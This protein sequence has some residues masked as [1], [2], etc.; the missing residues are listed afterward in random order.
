MYSLAKAYARLSAGSGRLN[1]V[2]VADVLATPVNQVSV[3]WRGLVMMLRHH[4]S[5]DVDEAFFFT[6]KAAM[7]HRDFNQE[8]TVAQWLTFIGDTRLETVENAVK[9]TDF[10]YFANA[11]MAGYKVDLT[12]SGARPSTELPK[13][14]QRDLFI[15]HKTVPAPLLYTNAIASVN[16]FLHR[17]YVSEWGYYVQEGG[18]TIQVANDNRV[19]LLSFANLGGCQ[20]IPIVESM[21]Q[22][23]PEEG[24]LDTP[25]YIN[26]PDFD[27]TGKTAFLSIGGRLLP[28][29][30][31][32]RSVG[33]RSFEFR[34]LQY[35]ILQH[36]LE[37]EKVIDCSAIRALLTKKDGNPTA[38]SVD[39]SFSKEFLKAYLTMP[40]TFLIAVNS[41]GVFVEYDD[42]EP[43]QSPG[44]FLAGYGLFGPLIADTGRLM[45][46][47]LIKEL[48]RWVVL[49][50]YG[51]RDNLLFEKAPWMG[52]NVVDSRCIGSKPK[53]KINPRHMTIG[54]DRFVTKTA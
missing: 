36:F 8:R 37:A 42:I 9:K 43:T 35:P 19:S 12:R 14:A 11:F 26:T 6:E 4:I 29:G 20:T 30:N 23:L 49:T 38:V 53:R 2:S 40:Q 21:I 47:S 46:Y 52:Q 41:P 7:Y 50:S 39:E 31:V 25:L 3:T 13:A 5:P 34:A 28:L 33:E 16:G 45:D 18:K 44:A 1:E 22:G 27:W 51:L 15:T 17:G 32:F 24:R 54:V 10:S 48:D